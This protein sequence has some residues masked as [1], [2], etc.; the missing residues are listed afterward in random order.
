MFSTDGFRDLFL[1]PSILVV[2]AVG[3]AMV[4]IT[5][6]SD[7][8]VGSILGLTA[9]LAGR[10]FLDTGLPILVVVLVAVLAGAVLGLVNG[11]LVAFARRARLVI[12]LGTLYVYRG[13]YLQWAGSDR[14]NASD[15]P[16]G[17]LSFGTSSLLGIPQLAIVSFVVLALAAYWMRTSRGGRELYAIG[18]DPAAATLYGLKDKQRILTA[19]RRLGRAR[20]DW[21]GSSTSPATAPSA[22]ASASASSSRPSGAAVIGGVA[23]FGAAAARSWAR[24]S[25]PTADQHRPRPADPRDPRLLAAGRRRPAHLGAIVLDK[26]LAERQHTKLLAE[27]HRS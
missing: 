12:T 17:L 1:T 3:Q 24:P 26:V 8:S 15:I 27:R 7:L 5:R 23:I 16:D 4:I 14:I 19:F 21:P 22:P 18:S 11:L 13:I 10:L 25:A 20:R 2:L 6:T 9:Y